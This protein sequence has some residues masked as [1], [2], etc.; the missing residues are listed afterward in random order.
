MRPVSG[1]VVS[2]GK[3]LLNHAQLRR[4]LLLDLLHLLPINLNLLAR[5][6]QDQ[7]DISGD[8]PQTKN[9]A[10][11]IQIALGA[12]A[13]RAIRRVVVAHFQWKCG[14]GNH[15]MLVS[16]LD[17]S[18]NCDGELPGQVNNNIAIAGL[19]VAGVR[20]L[21]GG[22]EPG[23]D[24]AGAR[25]GP[26]GA[27]HLRQINAAAA[28]LEIRGAGDANE[29]NS[30][31]ARFCPHQARGF[32]DFD[33]APGCFRDQFSAGVFERNVAA[34]CVESRDAF[35][36]CDADVSAVG[37]ERSAAGDR[38]GG[39]VPAARVGEKFAADIFHG[40]V[41]A[42]RNQAR[43]AADISRENISTGS[44]ERYPAIDVFGFNIAAAGVDVEAII[45]RNI[46][47]QGYPQA[48]A[49]LAAIGL[50]AKR[51]SLG[52]LARIHNKT[53]QKLRGVFLRGVCLQ[54]NVI[55]HFPG[56]LRADDDVAEIRDQA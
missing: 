26:D 20:L 19:Q 56:S 44:R 31:A 38:A 17:L 50:P 16:L 23:G 25:G 52:S 6:A 10:A 24:S 53:F 21:G 5:V 48:A 1:P 9:F 27:I 43:R 39:D 51:N 45:L 47:F 2:F 42:V 11:P 35:D 13:A 14:I 30:A 18:V 28:G 41:T 15:V 46:Y 4:Q 54:M 12:D 34:A 3:R 49:E 22:Y 29:A 36:G 55:V 33:L 32:A 7:A 37:V 40:D 8:G